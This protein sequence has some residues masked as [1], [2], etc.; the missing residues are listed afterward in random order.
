MFPVW[1]LPVEAPNCQDSTTLFK[2][3]LAI[4]SL[5]LFGVI[6]YIIPGTNHT[7][8]GATAAYSEPIH[9]SVSEIT[10]N[11]LSKQ[12]ANLSPQVLRPSAMFN[13]PKTVALL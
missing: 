7:V 12:P 1:P 10:G 3:S 4:I 11:E 9:Q 2:Q 13:S 8:S 6:S 5:C